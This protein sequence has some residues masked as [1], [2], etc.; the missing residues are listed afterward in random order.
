MTTPWTLA[1]DRGGIARARILPLTLPPLEPGQARLRIARFALTANNVTYAAFGAQM[2]YWDF[3][4]GDADTGRLPVWGFAVVDDPGNTPLQKGE[5]IWGY[6]PAASHATLT[7]ARLRPEGFADAS[8]HR[9]DLPPVYNRYTRCPPG[10]T[11]RSESIQALLQPLFLTAFLLDLHLRDT[12]Q[13]DSRILLTAASSKTALALAFL[14][15]RQSLPAAQVIGLTSETNRDFVAGTGLYDQV[16]DYAAIPALPAVPPATIAD[17][18]GSA[19]VNRALHHHLGP[20]LTA[21]HRIGATDWDDSTPAADLP[22]PRP[23]FFFAPTHLRDRLAA[24]G[25]DRLNAAQS[26]A[27]D[28]F[29]TRAAALLTLHHRQGPDGAL[30]AYQTLVAGRLPARD[31]LIIEP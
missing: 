31:A 3:F 9:A 23:Q 10:Q 17:F 14:L 7:P 2:R 18:A 5:R 13:G 15:Q 29:A 24:W 11:A 8:P 27:W 16:L 30:A 1:I 26:G 21:N 19:A 20:A 6:L 25:P 22:G 28:A 4:P 12:I